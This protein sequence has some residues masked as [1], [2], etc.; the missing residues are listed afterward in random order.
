M[1][2]CQTKDGAEIKE[3]DILC[4]M[5][6]IIRTALANMDREAREHYAVV[7]Q[8]KDMAGQVGGL[9][10]STTINITLT[11]V[12]DNPPKFPQKNLQL[13][14]AESAEVGKPVGKIAAHD[15]DLGPNAEIKYSILNPEAQAVFSIATS[16]DGR[17]GVISLRKPLNFERKKTYTLHIE[18]VNTHLDQRFFYLGPFKDTATL[19]IT[20][21]DVDEPPVFSMDYYILDVYENAPIGTAVGTVTAR[22]P[23]SK[24][25]RIRYFMEPSLNDDDGFII[26]P[27][28]GLIRTTY[29]LDR[30]DTPLHNITVSAAEI[31]N[32]S[33]VSHV[34]VTVQVLD[35]NDNPPE[36]K[37]DEDIIV[38]ENTRPGQV[39]QTVTAVDKDDFANGQRFSFSFPIGI[40]INPNFTLKDND[41]SWE[42]LHGNSPFRAGSEPRGCACWRALINGGLGGC[43]PWGPSSQPS[44]TASS[45]LGWHTTLY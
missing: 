38:C 22:D 8:A 39:I 30:E 28:S 26:E 40:P 14:V 10:G 6:C 44:S 27:D 36:I 37:T 33:M 16:R 2:D 25:S 15:A 1:K 17:E 18:G 7:I 5:N 20:V 35:R 19:K 34:P 24:N 32:P 9:S 23:D 42:C 12:N 4:S 29:M 31:D 13:Y 43:G 11:D 21:G 45:L 3:E 41:G